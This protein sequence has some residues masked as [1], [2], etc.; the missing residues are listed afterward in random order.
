[1]QGT[2]KLFLVYQPLFHKV[3]SKYQLIVSAE[4]SDDAAWQRYREARANDPS[5]VATVRTAEDTT[6]DKIIEAGQF[7]G[8]IMGL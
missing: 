8:I 5:A 6:L 4:I 3:N 7:E 1:M 2:D